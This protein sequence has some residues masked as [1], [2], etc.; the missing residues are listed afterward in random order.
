M[1]PEGW[2]ETTIGQ[3]TQVRR[4]ASPR[5]I[6]DPRWFSDSGPGWVRI[7]DVS[8]AKRILTATEQ[9]LSDEG[10]A[11]SVRLRP[12]DLVLSIAATIG[13]P[14]V[15][16][17]DACI[18]DGFVYFPDLDT[19]L[20][21]P[22]F[23]YYFFQHK[24]ADLAGQ[25]Q[26]GTQKNINTGIVE[27]VDIRLPP[28]G[29]QRKIATV[30]STIDDA[31]ESTQEV[32]GQLQIVKRTMVAE[33]LTRGLPGR[34]MQFTRA[35]AIEFPAE[36]T[37]R[38]CGELFEIQLGKM[39][40]AQ[41]KAGRSQLPYLRNENVRWLHI[42]MSDVATMHFDEREREK[43]RLRH[44]DLLA[45]EGRHIGRCAIW[46]NEL[47]DCYYQKALH[48]LRPRSSD[49]TTEYMQFFM[50]L[51]FHFMTDLV[52]EANTT[53]T[54]P[55]LPRERLLVL[56]VWYPPRAEQDEIVAVLTAE[57][58]REHR[59]EASLSALNTM[60]AAL[61]SALFSGELRVTPEEFAA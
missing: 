21:S 50:M 18:H 46:R 58:E 51:R 4:G 12:G 29:E 42:D 45:C 26:H 17:I 36:W 5:P 54:I 27:S 13:K 24:Q 47:D 48:R 60:K 31:I 43:F 39:M 55:H 10:A 1:T 40:S 6:Q 9:R 11:K 3:L 35:D 49:I 61:M 15:L 20:V 53:S 41:A 2:C 38:P 37:M 25:G 7:S 44:G 59:E 34:H 8:R 56:P 28:I 14:I 23:L 19:R 57:L 22:L 33:L 32:L 30:L 52:A 16:G